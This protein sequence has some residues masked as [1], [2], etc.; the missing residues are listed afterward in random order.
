MIDEVFFFP[1]T[2]RIIIHPGF[3]APLPFL[4]LFQF[5]CLITEIAKLSSNYRQ[6]KSVA[7]NEEKYCC[8]GTVLKHDNSVNKPRSKNNK[9]SQHPKHE[10]KIERRRDEGGR[11]K[12]KILGGAIT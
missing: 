2:G 5:V 12:Y 4:L 9:P 7:E 8:T 3:L 10:R 6:R 1:C 11:G